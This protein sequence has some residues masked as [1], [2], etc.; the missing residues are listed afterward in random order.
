MITA[1]TLNGPAYDAFE[2]GAAELHRLIRTGQDNSDAAN[3]I[4]DW[5]DGP[6]TAMTPE[7]RQFGNALSGDLYMLNPDDGEVFEPATDDERSPQRL[8]LAILAARERQEW[9]TVLEMLRKGP[10]DFPVDFVAFLRALAFEKLGRPAVALAF[11]QHANRLS[12]RNDAYQSKEL[13]LLIHLGRTDEMAALAW[14]Y[15]DDP[16]S[17]VKTVV[18][19]ASELTLATRSKAGPAARPELER[20]AEAVRSVLGRLPELAGDPTEAATSAQAH[21]TLGYCLEHL[22]DAAAAR[23][24]HEAALRAYGDRR[25]G[26]DAD[27]PVGPGLVHGD[28]P[29]FPPDRRL[30]GRALTSARGPPA[31]PSGPSS[32]ATVTCGL[33]SGTPAISSAVSHR[34]GGSGRGGGAAVASHR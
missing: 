4:R 16:V 23:E 25:A 31:P 28:G 12:P 18:F 29:D 34:R 27:R 14:K 19:A 11:A 6:W 7:Q 5:L 13:L 32:F 33:G 15:L 21:L 8:G 1:E 22:G 17:P 10:I 26:D 9:G 24:Q 30:I 3:A 20:I 2:A